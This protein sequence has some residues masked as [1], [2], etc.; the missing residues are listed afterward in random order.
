MYTVHIYTMYMYMYIPGALQIH[1]QMDISMYPDQSG[2]ESKDLCH[3]R[4]FCKEREGIKVRGMA[5]REGRDA[6]RVNITKDKCRSVQIHIHVCWMKLKY[7]RVMISNAP[8]C[9]L[10]ISM[11]SSLASPPLFVKYTT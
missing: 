10:A 8:V 7:L 1:W 3:G 9:T 11:A 6:R 2:L 5:R 4:N